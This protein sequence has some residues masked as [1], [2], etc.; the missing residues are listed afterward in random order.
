MSHAK[1]T[2]SLADY[3][4]YLSNRS[5]LSLLA[6]YFFIQDLVRHFQGAVLDVGCGIGEFLD[7]YPNGIG[8]DINPFA[9]DHCR[10]RGHQCSVA[11]ADKLPFTDEQFCGILAS[12]ILE[13]L[14]NP[15]KAVSEFARVIKPNGTLVITVPLKAGFAHDPTHVIF[16]QENDLMRIAQ[17]YSFYP[18]SIYCYPFNLKWIGNILY[19]CELR[20]VF[21]KGI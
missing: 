11:A 18:K 10:Q 6:R 13:H 1:N 9:V 8:V 21:I 14:H 7:R 17:P 4:S 19:F 16:L 5:R 3:Y 20:A 15:E 2:D 12:N